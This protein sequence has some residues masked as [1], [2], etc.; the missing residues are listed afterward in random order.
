M[1]SIQIPYSKLNLEFYLS[2]TVIKNAVVRK[3]F[4]LHAYLKSS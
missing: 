3:A 4:I 2:G 1:V